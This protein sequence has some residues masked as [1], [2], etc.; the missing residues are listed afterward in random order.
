MVKQR[1]AVFYYVM[2]MKSVFVKM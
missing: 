2:N 1:Q